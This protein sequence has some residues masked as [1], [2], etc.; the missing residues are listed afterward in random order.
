MGYGSKSDVHAIRAMDAL[1]LRVS[2]SPIIIRD[3]QVDQARD[4]ITPY[5]SDYTHNG[6]TIER[7][8]ATVSKRGIYIRGDSSGWTIRDFRFTASGPRTDSSI[9]AGIVING[10]AHDIV[11]E[12][13]HVSG[14]HG[15]AP[16]KTYEQGD[17]ISTERGN[18]NITIRNVT[19]E[20]VG[21]GCFDLKSSQTRLDDLTAIDAGHYSYRLWAQGTAGTLISINPGR[22][23]VQAAALSTDWT[24]DKLVAV[25]GGPLVVFDNAGG[26]V[27]IKACDLSRWTGTELS[28]GKGKVTFDPTCK[29]P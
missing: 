6:V 5:K 17:G 29:L 15:L 21:D 22:A 23:H 4:F 16:G 7:V 18:V 19:C 26:K 11:I 1:P 8:Q 25:G 20:D 13:G 14:F 27:A 9:P 28:K 2:T 10:T 24:I 3:V 12:R